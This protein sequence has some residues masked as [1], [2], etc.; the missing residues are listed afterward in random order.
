MNNNLKQPRRQAQ[1]TD[2]KTVIFNEEMKTA[3]SHHSACIRSLHDLEI[4]ETCLNL[5]KPV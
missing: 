5:F 2:C 4:E 1:V 3:I